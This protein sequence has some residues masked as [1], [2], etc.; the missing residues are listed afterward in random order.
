MKKSTKGAIAAGAGAVLLL[1]GAGSL[2]YWNA[3]ATVGGGTINSGHLTLTDSTAGT[4]ASSPWILD[5]AEDPASAAFDPATGTLVPGDVITKTCTYT[6]GAVGTHLRATV[7]VAG[8]SAGGALASALTVAAT[9]VDTTTGT[10]GLT[11]VTD[12]NN[13]D[14][15][16]ATISVT[17]N[18]TSANTTMDLAATLSDY[19]VTLTQVHA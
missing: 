5:G 16:T 8:G 18:G 6:L 14:V 17:F 3:Q 13:G 4:C 2:A 10:A 7:G 12:A 19:A 9:F 1:G 15:L 11:Q